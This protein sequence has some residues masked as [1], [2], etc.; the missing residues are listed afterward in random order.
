MIN[1]ENKRRSVCGILPVP[2]STVSGNDRPQVLYLYSGLTMGLT[3]A[4]VMISWKHNP[5][6]RE[7][8]LQR[9]TSG[10]GPWTTVATLQTPYYTETLMMPGNYF[11]RVRGR[12]KSKW[13]GWSA[14]SAELALDASYLPERSFSDNGVTAAVADDPVQLLDEPKNNR[15]SSQGTEANRPLFKASAYATTLNGVPVLLFDGTNDEL[16]AASFTVPS[17][18]FALYCVFKA[19]DT[20]GNRS[21]ITLGES[22]EE[23]GVNITSNT[24]RAYARSSASDAGA[25]TAFTDTSTF[26][27]VSGLFAGTTSR[28]LYLDGVTVASDTTSK[29]VT[30]S[31]PGLK[32][33]NRFATSHPL[34]GELAFACV[35]PSWT[36]AKQKAIDRYVL[37]RFFKVRSL[38]VAV[39]TSSTLA[40]SW[41]AF[42]GALRYDIQRGLSSSGPW[43]H[44]GYAYTN[45]YVS[46]GLTSAVEYFYR[47]RAVTASGPTSWGDV[48]SETV[49]ED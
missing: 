13:S 37:A 19:D 16:T 33:G 22:A 10:S 29:A 28:V 45:S 41:T 11:Y 15:D 31:S 43:A 6:A 49:S 20:A 4:D 2:D 46:S 9:A 12:V 26:H 27:F 42:S 18:P 1:T 17:Y 25:S 40:L 44:D 48:N 32:L 5:L 3:S 34:D 30:A 8:Q 39:D 38:L 35:I 23:F 24:I 7:Y 47:V 14:A 36:L 21:L